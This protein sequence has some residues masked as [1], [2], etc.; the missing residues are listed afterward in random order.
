MKAADQTRN[1]WAS[2]LAG[3]GDLY[4]SFLGSW[5]G[6]A[7]Q[8]VGTDPADAEPREGKDGV[9]PFNL[10]A[11]MTQVMEAWQGLAQG[12][13][14]PQGENPLARW[15]G[16]PAA[17]VDTS[18]SPSRLMM[19]SAL[20]FAELLRRASEHEML[21]MQGWATAMQKFAAEFNSDAESPVMVDSLDRLFTHWS[22]VGEAA[23]QEHARSD[24]YLQSQADMLQKSMRFRIAQRRTIEA[25]SRS[26]D[27]PTL[28][29]LDEA[30]ASI[31]ALKAETRRLRRLADSQAQTQ[32]Q[33]QSQLQVLRT[34]MAAPS[35]ALA[36]VADERPDSKAPPAR[37]TRSAA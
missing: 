3:R 2:L 30:F 23:L 9:D 36:L 32:A 31:H 11:T 33:L 19:E 13:I 28:T 1:Q 15:F 10:F 6:L 18:H 16:H 8:A 5:L 14:A 17:V 26:M 7:A 37:R 22:V 20:A 27:V 4:S 24:A 34:Q 12:W 25:V 29:D 21:R 35:T